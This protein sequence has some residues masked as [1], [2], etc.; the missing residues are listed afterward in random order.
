MMK[1]VISIFMAVVLAFTFAACGQTAQTEAAQ[2]SAEPAIGGK[3]LIVYFSW[4]TSGNTEKMATYIQE[5][6]GGVKSPTSVMAQANAKGVAQTQR[7][8]NYLAAMGK[9]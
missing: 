6:T 4:S 2:P 8:K 9:K 7:Y 5:Q 3:T 1:K